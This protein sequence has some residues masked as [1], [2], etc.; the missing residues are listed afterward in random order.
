MGEIRGG[1]MM[2]EFVGR[3]IAFIF[4]FF[5]FM[6]LKKICQYDTSKY[7]D[8]MGGIHGLI[9]HDSGGEM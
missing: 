8:G 3:V 1:K 4:F 2:F 6:H 9:K 5:F 7:F